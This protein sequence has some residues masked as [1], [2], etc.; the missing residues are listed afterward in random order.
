MEET[1]RTN[2]PM[3]KLI[4]TLNGIGMLSDGAT[5]FDVGTTI[6]ISTFLYLQD[7]DGWRKEDLEWGIKYG[8]GWGDGTSDQ[9]IKDYE[10]HKK[11]NEN[12]RNVHRLI[13]LNKQLKQLE[14]Q[15]K[16]LRDNSSYTDDLI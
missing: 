7:V 15:E 3:I 16:E 6:G 9:V 8:L 1:S 14:E 5:L 10:L 11:A 2:N 13:E 4:E 12:T